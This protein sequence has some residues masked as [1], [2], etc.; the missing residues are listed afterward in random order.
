MAVADSQSCSFTSSLQLC[1][2]VQKRFGIELNA[3]L[4]AHV[5]I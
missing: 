1:K 5:V 2:T 4:N 3:H